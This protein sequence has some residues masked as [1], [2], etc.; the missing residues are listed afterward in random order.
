MRMRRGAPDFILF[1]TVLILLSI[2]LVMVFSASAYFA[3]DP[4]GPFKDPF[5]FFK[6]QLFGAALGI[7]AMLFMMKYDYRNLKK[8]VGP[9]LVIAFVM[10]VAVLIP[11]VGMEVLGA[12]RWIDL[13]FI[14]F[15]PSELVKIFIIIFIAYGLSQKKERI[16][17][18]GTGLLPFLLITGLAALL[19]LAQPDLGTAATLCGTIFIML[20]AAGARGGH[21]AALAG[22]GFAAVAAAIYFEP[23]RMKR[24]TAFLD[25]EADPTGAGWNIL[26]ALMSLASGGLLGMGL[27]QGR[28]SKFLFLPER[29]TDFIFAAIG[30]ELGFIGGCLVILLFIL[31]AWRGF[32]IAITCPDS[33][34][35]LLAAGLVSGIVLQAFVNIGVVTGSLPVTGITLP[36]V[37][38]GSTSLIFSMMGVGILLNISR[39]SSRM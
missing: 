29:H 2:G 17:N 16:L 33:F 11:G 10:L 21:L 36:F 38:F 12:R 14:S 3:G 1:L 23:Y 15:Q 19:I 8:W 32:R 5:H 7:L 27:G 22:L 26:N 4:E 34:G 13:G 25:P 28:H 37:S 9:M 31:L 39:Y 30:E 18:L 20:F 6:R 35:S 24:F